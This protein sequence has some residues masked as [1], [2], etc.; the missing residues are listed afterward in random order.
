[1]LGL[2]CGREVDETELLI[3]RHRCLLHGI[4]QYST[5]V[6]SSTVAS[7]DSTPDFRQAHRE[8]RRAGVVH[9]M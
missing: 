9:C 8:K 5:V 3:N 1:M 7:T 4:V 6:Y 2:Q